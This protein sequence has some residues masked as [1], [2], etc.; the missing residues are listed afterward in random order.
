[1][2]FFLS[3]LFQKYS[4]RLFG[5]WELEEAK[6]MVGKGFRLFGRE[7]SRVLLRRGERILEGECHVNR[8]VVS[9]SYCGEFHC[10]VFRFA[11]GCYFGYMFR[12]AFCFF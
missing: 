9:A 12:Q 6:K 7:P 11:G 8:K 4:F 1:M 3:T 5:C 10:A 2:N